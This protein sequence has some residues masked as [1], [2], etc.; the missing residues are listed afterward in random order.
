M[1]ALEL[2]IPPVVWVVMH[3]AAMHY[4]AGL[5]PNL[6]FEISPHWS[7]LVLSLGLAVAFSG[8]AAFRAAKTTVNPLQPDRASSLVIVGIYRWTRNPMYVGA[9]LVLTAWFLFLQNWLPMVFLATFVAIL[10]RFQIVPEE[11]I[12]IGRFGEEYAAYCRRVP[13]WIGF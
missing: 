1:K 8:I 4:S 7:L 9:L 13:R 3:I 11:Q 5:L 2:K 12:L 10:T 6:N